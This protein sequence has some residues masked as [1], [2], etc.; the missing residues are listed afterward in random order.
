[1]HPLFEE[2]QNLIG[3]ARFLLEMSHSLLA[4]R[5]ILLR[6]KRYIQG[7]IRVVVSKPRLHPRSK[8]SQGKF[9]SRH[10]RHPALLGPGSSRTGTFPPSKAPTILRIDDVPGLS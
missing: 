8:S 5:M 2:C 9:Y 1:M 4:E 7:Q 3:Q 6:E 10:L